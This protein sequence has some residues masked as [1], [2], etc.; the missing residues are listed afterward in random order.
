[1]ADTISSI[2]AG[3]AKDDKR[4][5]VK[6][7]EKNCFMFVT[8]YGSYFTKNVPAVLLLSKTRAN[9]IKI[10]SSLSEKVANKLALGYE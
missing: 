1:M 8:I 2:P 6:T 4:I 7:I 10:D 5:T 3:G 9:I